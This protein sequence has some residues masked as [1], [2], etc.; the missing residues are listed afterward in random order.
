MRSLTPS[1]PR[2]SRTSQNPAGEDLGALLQLVR[3]IVGGDVMARAFI[4]GSGV[5][6]RQ[7]MARLQRRGKTDLL[8]H[9]SLML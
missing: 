4:P 1:R 8:G 6:D 3:E 7:R 2:R 5:T 9:F